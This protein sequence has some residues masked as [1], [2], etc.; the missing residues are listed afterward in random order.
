M[1]PFSEQYEHMKRKL[2]VQLITNTEPDPLQTLNIDKDTLQPLMHPYK[3]R[4]SPRIT[5]YSFALKAFWDEEIRGQ[6]PLEDGDPPTPTDQLNLADPAHVE[7]LKRF[8]HACA[9]P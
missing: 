9:R 1:V 7:L 6:A 5:W 8:A 4:G 3:R 2:L